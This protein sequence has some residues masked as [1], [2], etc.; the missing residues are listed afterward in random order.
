MIPVMIDYLLIEKIKTGNSL[1]FETLVKKTQFIGLS[2]ANRILNNPLD[3]EDVLQEAYLQVYL[4][5]DKLKTAQAFRSWFTKIVTN[6]ALHHLKK[7]NL[8]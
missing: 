6:L 8:F 2:I 7:K 5:I 3:A 1:A 4:N